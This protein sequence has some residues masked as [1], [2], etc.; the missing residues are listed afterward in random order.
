MESSRKYWSVLI[1]LIVYCFDITDAAEKRCSIGCKCVENTIECI[2]P[3]FPIHIPNEKT[4]S[5]VIRGKLGDIQEKAI[6]YHKKGSMLKLEINVDCINEIKP[7][8]FPGTVKNIKLVAKKISKINPHAFSNIDCQVFYILDSNISFISKFAFGNISCE[9][10]EV[11]NSHFTALDTNAL[12]ITRTN[13]VVYVFN[14]FKCIRKNAFGRSRGFEIIKNTIHQFHKQDILPEIFRNNNLTC[15]CSLRWFSTKNHSSMANNS[16]SG[17]PKYKGKA[18]RSEMFDSCD[19]TKES[20][21]EC[22]EP[23]ISNISKWN[24]S[25]SI[26]LLVITF[27]VFR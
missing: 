19:A 24:M 8:A 15:D 16:C 14:T 4:E 25:V 12:T 5:L 9:R 26:A 23:S 27:V 7:M 17:P 1:V 3:S 11:K 13:S 18:L 6:V 10:I 21:T 20:I 22:S 2:S